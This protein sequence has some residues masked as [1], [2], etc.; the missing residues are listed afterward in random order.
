[1]CDLLLKSG[2]FSRLNE[3]IRPNSFLARSDPRDVARVESCT[4]ICSNN[5][6]DAGPTNNWADP[7][8][9]RE[10]M[11]KLFAG[12]MKGRTM[13]VIPFCMGPIGS[14]YSKFGV[15]IS[16]SPY[17]VVNMKIMTRIGTRVLTAIGDHWF[18]PCLHSVGAP[19]EP[20]Q[21][22]VSWPCN[23]EQRYIVHFT[24]EPFEVM[25]YGSGYGGNALLGK[26]C[27]ALR[28]A[29]VMGRKQGWLAEHCLIL[30]L[31]SPEG[32]K[33][34]VCAGFPSACGKTN[35]AMLV[36]TIP[37]WSVRCVGDDIAWIHVADDG[38]MYAINPEAGFFGVAPGTSNVSNRSAM[39][40]MRKNTI[41]TNVALTPNGDVWWEGMTKETPAE[42]IDWTGQRWTPGC[43][44]KAAHPNSRYT[45]PASQC[46]VIDP[47]WD[48]PNG[49]PICAFIF[50]GR[51]PR[52]IPLVTEA[53][54]W[55]HGVFMGSIISSELTAAAEGTLGQVRRDPF[56]MLPFCGYHMGDYFNHW[57]GF[58]KKLGYL[59][60]K[61]FYVNW[62][63][64][65][66]NGN[67]LWPGFGENS[68]V[69]K[70]ICERVDGVGKAKSTP[71]G[72]V[73]TSDALDVGG[74]DVSEQTL[75]QLLH[76]SADEWLEELP[77]I[78][79]FYDTF[80]DRLPQG[81]RTNLEKLKLRLLAYHDTPTQNRKLV[82]WVK[83]MKALCEP[84]R[85][86]WIDGSD[87]EFD[88]LCD[89]LV[90]NQTFTRLNPE[91]RPK[92]FLAR[93]DPKD[94]IRVRS[95]VFVC[96]KV[97]DDA[98]PSNNWADPIEM[99]DKLKALFA[100]S[101]KGRTMYVVPFCMGPLGSPY[102]KY[103]VEITDSPYAVIGIRTLARTGRAVL[104][105]L[106]EG[107][108]FLPCLHSVGCPLSPGESDVPWPCNISKRVIAHFTD[109]GEHAV[110]SY[111]SMYGANSILNKS[112]GALRMATVMAKQEGWIVSRCLTLGLTSPSG[113]K[114]YVCAAFPGGCGKT[115][116]AM[117]VPTIPGWSVRCVG[118]DIAWLRYGDDG[119]LYAINPEIGFFDIAP[120]RSYMND[121]S[122]MDTL[123]SHAI[124]TNV[125]LTPEGDVWWEGLTREEPKSLVDWQGAQ[126]TPG[127]GRKAAEP[128]ARYLVSYKRCP[129]IDKEY[130]NPN[131][132]PISA[133]ILGCRRDS[134]YPLVHESMSF[135]QGVLLGALM[136]SNHSPDGERISVP[137]YDPF[138]MISYLGV[139]ISQYMGDW[140][141]I[142]ERLGYQTPKIFFVN[143]FRK[144]KDSG[145]YLWPGFRENI[146]ILKWIF[147]RIDGI[148]L[149]RRTPL[150]FVPAINQGELE[151]GSSSGQSSTS[152][153]LLDVNG[154]DI[155][156]EQL[157]ELVSVVPEE[158]RQELVT[159]G[160]FLSGLVSKDPNHQAMVLPPEQLREWKKLEQKFG[161][162]Q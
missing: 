122:I 153:Q 9:M 53:L 12:S 77:D 89:I 18:L 62:F 149:V 51:R 68:R 109:V 90:S 161:V 75:H 115:N 2:T 45:T 137:R 13:Y 57:F 123:S 71:I 60:P 16:D 7:K 118:D 19:L 80:G 70:W 31:T 54:V 22:D 40:T 5:K 42:L 79:K 129:V 93:S 121:R 48:N 85:V 44:R 142:R 26:K 150:G 110:Y 155:G 87:D 23:P 147:N 73:P 67:F 47:E 157:R 55:D 98:G 125:A 95:S 15:E 97:R 76:V 141:L 130:D 162:P 133:V 17:V 6:D 138:G 143:W 41:F 64:T 140:G 81:L 36:P 154:L 66:P 8:E 113:K 107:E 24:D 21:K 114:H 108:S 144:S 37:G 88:E 63:R 35:L 99:R 14:P 126:W 38:R 27:Y 84:S 50:G 20:G 83:E 152:D 106:N 65:G 139:D 159:A 10:K 128:N 4:F 3:K 52:L 100:G 96:C 32:K 158:W 29:S 43:G 69:L 104:D 102:S 61:I 146:R 34:Y 134:V 132:V 124:F 30:G 59:V 103:G 56:A 72:Y 74:I 156:Q 33:Y 120:G 116:L 131:G 58:K 136:S 117:L 135:G 39:I 111:G 1:M 127:C 105:L 91:L 86:R 119:R 82:S 11:T 101:M 145:K 46:P 151:M 92:S 148:G 94:V 25:S 28:I 160:K 112:C 49:V 78:S